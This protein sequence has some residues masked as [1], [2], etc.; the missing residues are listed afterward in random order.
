MSDTFPRRVQHYQMAQQL[1]KGE[2]AE[3]RLDRHF[4]DRFLIQPATRAEQ[5]KGIDRHLTH[6]TSGETYT[7]EYKTDWTATRTGNAFIETISVDTE[8]IAGWAYTAEASWLAYYLPQGATV[9]LI[10]FS[11]LRIHLPRWQQC[12][13]PAPPIP[14]R[15]YHTHGLLVPL[16]AVGQIAS[17]IERV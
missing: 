11:S 14:N 6:R 16:S 13:P 9:Y 5:R 3:A 8:Q 1:R 12:Y 4:A 17:R 2:A 7:I 10:A 15:G